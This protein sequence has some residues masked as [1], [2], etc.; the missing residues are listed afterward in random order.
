MRA[1][2]ITNAGTAP[3]AIPATTDAM[4]FFRISE[5]ASAGSA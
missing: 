3:A 5:D 1:P 2:P 4:V